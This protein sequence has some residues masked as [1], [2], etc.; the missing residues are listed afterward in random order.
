MLV[1]NAKRV[2]NHILGLRLPKSYISRVFWHI[3]CVW[4]YKE[5][6]NTESSAAA[7]SYGNLS[8]VCRA[9]MND[10]M[11]WLRF[12]CF[13]YDNKEKKA[14][15]YLIFYYSIHCVLWSFSALARTAVHSIKYINNYIRLTF[16]I[17]SI[18]VAVV[19]GFRRFE[20]SHF[21]VRFVCVYKI[22][23]RNKIRA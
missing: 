2:E 7:T 16:T 14:K 23:T 22:T 6:W 21:S 10:L 3:N 15:Q 9:K 5:R 11:H 19:C 1:P 18:V 17:P 8:V 20:N 4:R 12:S 13:V